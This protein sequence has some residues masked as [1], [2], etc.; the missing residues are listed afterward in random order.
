MFCSRRLIPIA[1][2]VLPLQIGDLLEFQKFRATEYHD[3]AIDFYAK[4]LCRGLS[5][6]R[7]AAVQCD[8]RDKFPLPFPPSM[9]PSMQKKPA[10]LCFK[11]INIAD[12]AAVLNK[13]PALKSA[14]SKYEKTKH[15]GAK[16]ATDLLD[17]IIDKVKTPCELPFP[18]DENDEKMKVIV[19]AET[20]VH[21]LCYAIL[22]HGLDPVWDQNQK[23]PNK[24]HS[25]EQARKGGLDFQELLTSELDISAEKV[26]CLLHY[27]SLMAM[28]NSN[29]TRNV[30]F[31]IQEFKPNIE[32]YFGN[33]KTWP[34]VIMETGTDMSS[35]PIFGVFA[36]K[37]YGFG[38]VTKSEN[39]MSQEEI[40]QMTNP[41]LLI[42]MLYC[43]NTGE[44]EA[45]V[46]K[47]IQRFSLS[48]GFKKTFKCTGPCMN[49]QHSII[50][51]MDALIYNS[52]LPRSKGDSE[53]NV[54]TTKIQQF[55]ACNVKRDVTKAIAA[56]QGQD[57]ISTGKWGCGQFGGCLYLKILQQILAGAGAHNMKTMKFHL[58]DSTKKERKTCEDLMNDIKS[59]WSKSDLYEFLTTLDHKAFP[60]D[61]KNPIKDEDINQIFLALWRKE[62][63]RKQAQVRTDNDR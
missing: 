14:L 35:N 46:A 62:N 33:E 17:W 42:Y 50:V 51:F 3:M 47:N 22:G 41:E 59:A 45:I 29:K 36:N 55:Y 58:F 15:E 56:F 6:P 5:V 21:A 9:R 2:G 30:S 57:T 25:K 49:E 63:T 23:D 38:R 44:K 39:G 53:H 12:P 11:E 13:F 19:S 4:K 34:T 26:E 7:Y 61:A 54:S 27:F 48:S 52:E 18:R 31:H 24:L 16:N 1:A 28:E 32:T 37:C 8:N 60:I 10:Y 20:C 40:V 43:G